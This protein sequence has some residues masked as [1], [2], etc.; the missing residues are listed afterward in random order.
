MPG[1][2]VLAAAR[3]FSMWTSPQS[4]VNVLMT[5]QLASL[6]VS[7]SKEQNGSHDVFY[8]LDSKVIRCHFHNILLV[9]QVSPVQ[10]GRGLLKGTNNKG[11]ESLGII[12]QADYHKR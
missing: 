4:Y 7:D 5:G 8:D 6:R 10:D 11:Q 2:L 12:L 9:T 3:F 1:K